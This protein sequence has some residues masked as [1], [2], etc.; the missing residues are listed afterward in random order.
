M[1]SRVLLGLSACVLTAATA[2]PA[3]AHDHPRE[4]RVHV[5]TPHVAP[6]AT[7]AGVK[8]TG[9]AY[10]SSFVVSPWSDHVFY[11]LTD[12]GPNVDGPDGTKIEPLPDFQPA[13]GEFVLAHGK[14]VLV[15]RI[16]LA[17]KDGTPYNGQ[18]NPDNSTNETITDLQ[19]N[20]LPASE[21]GYDPE[22]LVVMR[23]GTFWVSDEYGPF[24][25]HF[26]RR[27]RAIERLSPGQGLPAELAWREPNKGMEGLSVTPDGRTLVGIM[28]AGLNA[29]GGPKSKNLSAVRIVTV[30]LRSRATHQYVYVLHNTDGADTGVS[31]ISALDDHRFLVDERDG[32]F[33]PGANKKLFAI[34]LRGATDVTGKQVEVIAG[35]N[36]T[37][38]TISNL[39]AAGITPV[40]SSLYLD[41]AGLVTRIDPTGDFFGHDKIEGV[42]VVDH[43]R[44]LV[45]SND[46][47][48]GISGVNET[49]APFTLQAKILPNGQQDD[50][51]LLQ[52]DLPAGW[53]G[54]R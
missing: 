19:G 14:A 11:G 52:I 42:A 9:E 25:T 51:E 39:R 50:G 10:G 5:Y 34:D 3:V 30:D 22:G 6:L 44:R 33:E 28:Q 29:P 38:T 32:D 48:F 49:T 1:P 27:G 47:D 8:I 36:D 12:R 53:P 43:G 54:R 41:V 2:A 18:V 24:I 31:E 17:A 45:I 7:V 40:S 37:A 35:K 21:N 4:P 46:S 23:D 13:I 15:R 20:V 16:G 26:D